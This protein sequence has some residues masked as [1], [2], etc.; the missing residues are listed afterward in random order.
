MGVAKTDVQWVV[1]KTSVLPTLR[2]F[3]AVPFPRLYIH[4]LKSIKNPNS[5]FCRT[6]IHILSLYIV[7]HRI[8]TMSTG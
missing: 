1:L 2:K 6:Q 7:Y 3:F 8:V 5:V 4:K